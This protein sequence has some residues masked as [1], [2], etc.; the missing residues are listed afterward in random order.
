MFGFALIV[1]ILMVVG[2]IFLF[3][4]KPKE[5]KLENVQID[6]MIY[7]MLSYT[8]GGE[9][10][11]ELTEKCYDNDQE[12]CDSAKKALK[13]VLEVML[14]KSNLVVGQQLY[15]YSLNITNCNILVTK[16]NLTGE[17]IGSYTPITK[18]IVAISK[19]YY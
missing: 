10:V 9:N 13:D 1:V 11:R 19:F 8:A 17:M 4:L 16:G 12:A 7:S 15:G 5:T 18:D 6:N 2:V 14:K 3:F